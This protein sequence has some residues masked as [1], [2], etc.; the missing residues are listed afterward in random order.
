MTGPAPLRALK[1][2]YAL[3]GAALFAALLV[4]FDAKAALALVWQVGALGVLGLCAAYFLA[5]AADNA[6]WLAC[7]PEAR[8]PARWFLRLT[9]IR[10]VGEAYN[11]V[12]PAG[13][14]GGEPVKAVLLKNRH[15]VSYRASS[16][17][18]VLV[19][20]V[21][22]VG[23][24]AFVLVA[25][26][27][28]AA[29][30]VLPA[31]QQASAWAGF[32]VLAAMTAAFVLLPVLRLASRL[33][34]WLERKGWGR[35][36]AK[37]L[38]E[39]EAVETLVGGFAGRDRRRYALATLIGI[40]HWTLGVGEM[41]LALHLLGHSVSFAEAMVLEAVLQLA[42]TVSF[43]VPA[44]LGTQ[45]GAVAITV[46]AVTGSPAAGLGAALLRRVREVVYTAA[47][48]ALGAWYAARRARAAES[49]RGENERPRREAGPS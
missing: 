38:A 44:N 8:P 23:Q 10:L 17:S 12:M 25:F 36:M 34:R 30:A 27:L 5:F 40:A 41:W 48:F 13:G 7:L 46:A 18:I 2:A 43:F 28:M 37:G 32:A 3:A 11:L 4:A 39:V 15:G 14:F 20:L 1:L 45:D 24:L 47:G 16:A 6:L 35:R 49:E 29:L 26:V 9:G 42:R 33:A 19:R 22:T 31:W 21:N